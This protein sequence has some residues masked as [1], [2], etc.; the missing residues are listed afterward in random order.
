MNKRQW[1]K[2]RLLI[3][4]P[5]TNRIFYINVKNTPRCANYGVLH[6]MNDL[7]L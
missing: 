7:T 4:D 1:K 3:F 5:D 6:L 2:K